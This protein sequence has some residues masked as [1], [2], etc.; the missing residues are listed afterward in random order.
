MSIF[1]VGRVC[2]KKTGRETGRKCVIVDVLDK[3][4]V[5]VTGPKE[6]TG[7]RRRRANASHLEP[8]ELKLEIKRNADDKD[9]AKVFRKTSPGEFPPE[10]SEKK[11]VVELAEEKPVKPKPPRRVRKAV[12]KPKTAEAESTVG[13]Q[14][15]ERA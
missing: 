2:V 1:D 13:E 7:V 9:V 11:P 10:V 5:F 4:F 6:L 8:L 3:N 12:K 15:N 14:Q